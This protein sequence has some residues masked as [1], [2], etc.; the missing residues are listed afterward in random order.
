[1]YIIAALLLARI[2]SPANA[3]QVIGSAL[4]ALLPVGEARGIL[5]H[6][7]AGSGTLASCSLSLFD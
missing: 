1:M 5:R 4:C 7:D 3:Q 6:F 2:V